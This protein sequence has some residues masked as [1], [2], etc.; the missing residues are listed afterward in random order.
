MNMHLLKRLQSINKPIDIKQ[1]QSLSAPNEIGGN[2]LR[3]VTVT[4]HRAGEVNSQLLGAPVIVSVR[5]A[6]LP[7]HCEARGLL[8]LD[9][10]HFVPFTFPDAQLYAECFWYPFELKCH[11]PLGDANTAVRPGC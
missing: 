8:A 11:F 7:L 4:L 10:W 6:F 9:S 3:S 5:R 2:V 1:K